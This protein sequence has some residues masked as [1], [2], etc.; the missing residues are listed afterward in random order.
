[1]L[2]NTLLLLLLLQ[3]QLRISN[4]VTLYSS[5]RVCV[6]VCVFMLHLIVDRTALVRTPFAWLRFLIALVIF[7]LRYR[8]GRYDK[9]LIQSIYLSIFLST[10]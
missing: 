4:D 1:M 5:I 9:T 2:F 3:Q 7:C 8:A 10:S 6:C